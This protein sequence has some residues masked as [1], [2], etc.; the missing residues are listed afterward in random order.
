MAVQI[1]AV[2]FTTT[3][4]RNLVGLSLTPDEVSSLKEG[5]ETNSHL[6]PGAKLAVAKAYSKAIRIGL[7]PSLAWAGLA[8]LFALALPWPR[9]NNRTNNS[10]QKNDGGSD[11]DNGSGVGDVALSVMVPSAETSSVKNDYSAVS[12]PERNLLVSRLSFDSLH[13]VDLYDENGRWTG[14][15]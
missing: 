2:A 14:V 7:A 4:T 9:L 10:E 8:L 12:G 11:N 6:S 1:S 15:V 5:S 13:M 3:L